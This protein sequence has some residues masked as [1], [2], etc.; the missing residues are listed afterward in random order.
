MVT[1]IVLAIFILAAPEPFRCVR[2]IDN[3]GYGADIPDPYGES[4]DGWINIERRKEAIECES[5]MCSRRQDGTYQFMI[6]YEKLILLPQV[7]TILHD[8]LHSTMKED[9]TIW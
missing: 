5:K 6:W 9:N 8:D 7:M 3:A 4:A 1:E 2:S